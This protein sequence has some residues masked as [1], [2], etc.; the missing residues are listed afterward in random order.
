MSTGIM[1]AMR[2]GFTL[3]EL[4][5]VIAI[6]GI[7][8]S[9]VLVSLNSARNK[10]KGSRALQDLK[11]ISDALTYGKLEKG[12]GSPGLTGS[13]CSSCSSCTGNLQNTSGSCYTRWVL[14]ATNL[15]NNSGGAYM[16]V[17]GLTRDPWGSPYILDEN[18]GEFA[19][20]ICRRDSLRSV[21]ADG[22]NG[23]SDDLNYTVP[24]ALPGC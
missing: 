10:A 24:F 2:R 11:L 20:N 4:L 8:S 7:L 5:V 17:A 15:A 22:V 9:V 3:I 19:G 23:T 16:N 12:T 18:E 6:I 14:S 1:N 21:G 13:G